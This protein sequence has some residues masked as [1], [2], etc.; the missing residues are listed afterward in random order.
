MNTSAVRLL[1]VVSPARRSAS[2]QLSRGVNH[3][4]LISSLW[5]ERRRPARP[6]AAPPSSRAEPAG[7]RTAPREMEQIG[8]RGSCRGGGIARD[9]RAPSVD[10]GDPRR[11]PGQL[12]GRRR[13]RMR[14]RRRRRMRM[15]MRMRMRR[16][17]MRRRRGGG[18]GGGGG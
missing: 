3:R 6:P 9:A 12:A 5:S 16:M 18:G 15:R 11:R 8:R 4:R 1:G 10:P 13:R 17:R 14:M 7:P 2:S